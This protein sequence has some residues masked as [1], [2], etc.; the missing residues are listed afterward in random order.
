MKI[1]FRAMQIGAVVVLA[2]VF[3]L[4]LLLIA[5]HPSRARGPVTYYISPTGSDW[6]S[7]AS[8]EHPFA[9]IQKAVDRAQPGDLITLGPGIYLQDV[10]SRRDGAANAPITITGPAD[11][12][13]KG[14]G[15]S[16]IVEINH[17]YLTLEGFTID[18]LWGSPQTKQG[19]REKL[20][21]VVG[22]QPN[23]GVTGLRVLRMTFKNAGGECLRM[24]YFA[25]HNE[26]G[27]SRFESCGVHDFRFHAGKRNGEAIYIGTAPEQLGNGE[28]P[29]A[30]PDRSNENWI[31]G[32]TFNT[33]ANECVDIK[34]ASSGNIVEH[35]SCTGQQDPNSGG[36]DARGGGNIFRYNE[37]FGNRGAGIRLGG[38]GA[39][40]GLNNQVYG[41]NLHDNQAGGIKLVRQPQSL[42]GNTLNNNRGGNL[43]GAGRTALDPARACPSQAPPAGLPQPTIATA[44][45]PPPATPASAGSQTY[46][47]VVDTYINSGAPDRSYLVAERIKVDR[48]PEM[49]AL[50]RFELPKELAGR[51]A[52]LKLYAQNTAKHGGVVY[53]VSSGWNGDITWSS[54]PPLGAPVAKIGQVKKG[55]WVTIDV[56]AAVQPS[57]IVT[58]AIVPESD[59]V[60]TYRSIEDNPSYA[61]QIV[62]E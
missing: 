31:H 6:D 49:W 14:A 2:G 59:H 19:F 36:F 23:D 55:A 11:A 22:R 51:R 38:D 16:R 17:D 47:P 57:G 12:V 20:L 10:V 54:R 56:A 27:A 52:L 60:A 13:V 21:Y 44:P 18:G 42:C 9:T 53:A 35:N 43:V 34:E 15:G 46:Q 4:L 45:A 33:Q 39:A 58:L 3:V 30:D 5:P 40:D 32:N 29:T 1:N 50:L 8:R 7:G 48:T 37:S 28:N 61:P 26:I 62:V 24:R 25:Q 41:N